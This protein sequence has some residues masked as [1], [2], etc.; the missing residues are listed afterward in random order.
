VRCYGNHPLSRSAREFRRSA[1]F[2]F[3]ERISSN[4]L[5]TSRKIAAGII[6]HLATARFELDG[7]RGA[8]RA[9]GRN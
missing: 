3:S 8:V 2:R 5:L 6:C 4:R 9:E 7:Y 1:S